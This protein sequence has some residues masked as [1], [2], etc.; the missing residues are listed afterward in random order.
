MV[1]NIEVLSWPSPRRSRGPR[2]PLAVVGESRLLASSRRGGAAAD[3]PY[4]LARWTGLSISR[5][6][7]YNDPCGYRSERQNANHE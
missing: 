4:V 7:R 6:K 2:R 5:R 3:P 1:N